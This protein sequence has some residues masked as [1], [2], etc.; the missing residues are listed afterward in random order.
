MLRLT[1]SI[2]IETRWCSCQ[3][4]VLCWPSGFGCLSIRNFLTKIKPTLVFPSSHIIMRSTYSSIAKLNNEAVDLFKNGDCEQ[5][6]RGLEAAIK[7]VI[8]VVRYRSIDNCLEARTCTLRAVKNNGLHDA[9]NS[10]C[11]Y[12]DPVVS[13]PFPTGVLHSVAV[14]RPT[15]TR[16]N[17]TATAL[18]SFAV[19]L[20]EVCQDAPPE[21]FMTRASVSMLYNL[22]FM[23]HWQATHWGISSCIPNAL[24]LYSMALK[25]IPPEENSFYI[26][27]LAM[28]IWN[29]MGHIYAQLLFQLHDAQVCLNRLRYL[30]AHR[31]G[32]RCSLPKQDYE[33]FL[34]SAIFQGTNLLLAPAA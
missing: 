3:L 23:N 24:Q 10:P 7:Q 34:L 13:I 22:A 8:S 14:E 15:K 32:L 27:H 20:P 9:I 11:A 4:W 31:T 30:L 19:N 12:G 26:D 17:K 1:T 33:I 25:L 21:Q 29:N 2:A 5:A 28:A 16:E 6:M 18:Y